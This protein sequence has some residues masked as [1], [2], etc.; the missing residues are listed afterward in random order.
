MDDSLLF[1]T[2]LGIVAPWHIERIEFDPKIKQLDIHIS[3]QRGATFP[4]AK[5]G[6]EYKAYDTKDKT[7]R[8]L[9]FFEHECYLHCRTPRI[10][11]AAVG[12]KTGRFHVV[13]RGA[14]H[15]TL[16]SHARQMRIESDQRE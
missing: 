2:A 16:P 12:R 14:C 1:E 9:N 6:G 13:V 4:S 7:W 3:F 11:I 8:H 10:R 15:R 5:C